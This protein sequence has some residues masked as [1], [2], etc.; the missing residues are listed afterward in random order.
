MLCQLLSTGVKP[1]IIA[2]LN[3]IITID[4]PHSRS[5]TENGFVPLSPREGSGLAI[6]QSLQDR[7]P[8]FGDGPLQN[9]LGIID[10]TPP[11]PHTSITRN[12]STPRDLPRLRDYLKL[13]SLNIRG[14]TS[15]VRGF[16]QDKWFEIYR[17]LMSNHIAILATQESHLTDELVENIRS[18]FNTKL[19]ILHS[20]L[21]ET[22]N[23]A[24]VAFVINKGLL[25]TNN[26]KCEIIIPGRAIPKKQS[27]SWMRSSHRVRGIF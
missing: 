24:G 27:R 16:R 5:S 19:E 25:E 13:V 4:I 20:P 7:R 3:S 21:P 14:R 26:I 15:T 17:V 2:S 22:R 23:A 6:D 1:P 8:R 12:P 10:P 18:T 11:T 9:P